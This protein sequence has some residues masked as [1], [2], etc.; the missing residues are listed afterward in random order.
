MG[1]FPEDRGEDKESPA[2][3]TRLQPI[4]LTLV[5]LVS[6]NGGRQAMEPVDTTLLPEVEATAADLV[7]GVEDRADGLK[8]IKADLVI[9]FRRAPGEKV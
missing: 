9:C 4:I 5:L 8:G 7:E 1:R 2:E 6:G 3:M